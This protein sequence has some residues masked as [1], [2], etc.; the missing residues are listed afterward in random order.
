M[1]VAQRLESLPAS[2]GL[3]RLVARISAG[4]WFE[5]YD[6]FMLAYI[7]LGLIG[8][9]LYSALGTGLASLAGFAGSGFA[10]MFVG[11]LLF[12][13]VSDR[14]GRKTTFT[15]SL[16]FYSIMTAAMA[17]A[18]SAPAIDGLR[19]VACIGIGVQIVTIDAYIAEIAPKDVRGSLIALSQ[20]ICYT[21]VPV[22]AFIASLLV[23][24]S[25][26]GVDGWRWVALIGALGALLA[27]PIQARLPESPRWLQS[28]GRTSE[29]HAAL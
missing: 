22:V 21:A 18:R 4:G 15:W 17:L 24:H 27:W 11:T 25:I 12:G 1:T 20:A 19:F 7:A 3:R 23:P 8:S 13:W 26:A 6:L 16:V 28:R 14:Y 2:G 29:A 5:F 9:G 10:G